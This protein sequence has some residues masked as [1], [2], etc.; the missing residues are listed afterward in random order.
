MSK[1]YIEKIIDEKVSFEPDYSKIKELVNIKPRQANKKRWAWP[2]LS[3]GL[4]S[5][6]VIVAIFVSLNLRS[7]PNPIPTPTYD[8]VHFNNYSNN[9]N[10][11]GDGEPLPP[12]PMVSYSIDV[13]KDN[14]DYNEEFIIKYT[15]EDIGG[16]AVADRNDLNVKI[17]SDKFEFLSPTEYH[18]DLETDSSTYG[19]ILS[20]GNEGKTAIYPIEMELKVKAKEQTDN[21]ENISFLL[22]FP[23]KDSY[24]KMLLRDDDYDKGETY[25]C[26]LD[27]FTKDFEWVHRFY[28]LNDDL[29]T[30]LVDMNKRINYYDTLYKRDDYINAYTAVRYKSLNRLY[31][32]E[33]VTKNEYMKRLINHFT[34]KRTSIY[35]RVERQIQDGKTISI[36]SYEYYSRNLRVGLKDE[37]DSLYELYQKDLEG[38]IQVIRILLQMLY[39]EGKITLEEYNDEIVILDEEGILTSTDWQELIYRDWMHLFEQYN[40]VLVPFKDYKDYY[41]DMYIEI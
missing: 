1:N 11:G 29:G 13:E 6:A 4:I 19:N 9:G 27:E 26:M 34:N 32:K 37:Q 40:A 3:I 16:D 24:K 38:K 5:I 23:L 14:Y 35:L 22:E 8:G 21:V 17:L 30:L 12:P 41:L 39:V 2:S 15:I 18:F 28:F 10:G 36:V 7:N 20:F 31:E 25:Q 33:L